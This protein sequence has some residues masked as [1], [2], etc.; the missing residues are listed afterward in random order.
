MR[1]VPALGSNTDAHIGLV[2]NPNMSSALRR[3]GFQ[4]TTE[5]DADAIA[6]PCRRRRLP[7]RNA[8]ADV[9]PV[10]YARQGIEM[11]GVNC[12]VPVGHAFSNRDLD[13]RRVAT[14]A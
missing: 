13:L 10:G 6:R 2:P 11:D 7:R 4:V 9:P 3:S 12:A 5:L 14:P 1:I 8:D